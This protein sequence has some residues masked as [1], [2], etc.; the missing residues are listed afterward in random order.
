[1][2][3]TA[4]WVREIENRIKKTGQ[5]PSRASVAPSSSSNRTSVIMGNRSSV[6]RTPTR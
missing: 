2:A 3:L 6:V 5:A 1:M 4:K